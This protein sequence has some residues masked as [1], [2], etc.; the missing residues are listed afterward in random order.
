MPISDNGVFVNYVHME[1]MLMTMI[2]QVALTMIAI[3]TI[4]VSLACAL[5][6]TLLG[7]GVARM[8]HSRISI[9]YAVST[10]IC[11]STICSLIIE[12]Q[13]LAPFSQGSLSFFI[14]LAGLAAYV[15]TFACA[16]RKRRT[17]IA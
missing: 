16:V 17:G 5:L 13:L 1:W 8:S 6:G 2:G 14:L 7:A 11:V 12:C 15:M 10:L 9:V 3:P 4:L